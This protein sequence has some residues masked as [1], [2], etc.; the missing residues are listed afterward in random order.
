MQRIHGL[1]IASSVELPGLAQVSGFPPADVELEL[2]DSPLEPPREPLRLLY[3]SR[4]DATEDPTDA[5][6]T[7]TQD[8]RTMVCFR[9]SDGTAIDVSLQNGTA[10]IVASIAP[11]QTLEDLTT[12]LYGAVLGFVLRARGVLAMHASCVADDDGAI[13]IVGHSGAGKSTT[14]A[15]L[16]RRGWRVLSDD[17]TAL[18]PPLQPGS[19]WSVHQA[20]NHVRLWPTS[21]PIVLG[22]EGVLQRIT[23]TW[24]K[25]RYPVDAAGFVDD[26]A[27]LRGIFVLG[28]RE[29]TGDAPRVSEEPAP[30]RLLTL[31][32]MTYANYL[33]DART[34]AIELHRLGVLLGDVP[35]RTLVAHRDPR[36]IGTLCEL[37]EREARAMRAASPVVAR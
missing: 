12:Y 20:F 16:H 13:L 32:T 5:T 1:L 27:P 9:Y 3:R 15:A 35:V 26:G 18:S 2:R 23:P 4:V 36:R 10:K 6:L 31:A 29:E 28:Q 30:Q 14:A 17:L 21:E 11:E 33:H 24:E 22:R 7:V 8:S 19:M 25:L 34:R 37:M